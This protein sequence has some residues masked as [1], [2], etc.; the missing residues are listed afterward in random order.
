[1]EKMSE[2]VYYTAEG[3]VFGNYWSGGRGY[4]RA[5]TY[6]AETFTAM[7]D[8]IKKDFESGALDGGMGYE[9]LI[10]AL[11]EITKHTTI[12]KKGIA[13]TNKRVSRMW[14]GKINKREAKEVMRGY[15]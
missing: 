12:V 3:I 8:G 10:G 15:D 11:M 5:H 7:K 1:M 9:S 6:S 4:F 14:L 13:F 2:T